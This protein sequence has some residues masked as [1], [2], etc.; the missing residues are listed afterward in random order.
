MEDQGGERRE[1]EGGEGICRLR[2]ER[3]LF[4][5]EEG[6]NASLGSQKT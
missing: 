2:G 4:V 5:V 6:T 3:R 1:I